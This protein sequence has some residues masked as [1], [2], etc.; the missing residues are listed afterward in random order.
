MNPTVTVRLADEDVR[1][2]DRRGD[3]LGEAFTREGIAFAGIERALARGWDLAVGAQGRT[4]DEPGR[5]TRSTLGGVVRLTGASRQRGRVLQAELEWMGMYQRAAFEGTLSAR[6]GIVRVSPRLRLGWGESLPLQLGFPL[7]GDDGF[8]GYH[9]GERRGDREAMASL[10]FTVP[11]RGPLLGLVEVATGGTD[12][13]AAKFPGGG[14]TTGIRAG[15]G[16][17]TP[18]GPVRFGYGLGLRG[19]D[20]LFVRL[21]RWF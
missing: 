5:S 8:P 20:A 13:A 16:A 15:A 2:F 14:W 6:L 7:G 9:I 10:L 4:W 21:G 12:A 17:E 18:V 3:E 1:R 19:R 11:I